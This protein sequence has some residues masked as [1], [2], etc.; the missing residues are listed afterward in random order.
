MLGKRKQR[1]YSTGKKPVRKKTTTVRK[2]YQRSNGYD[3]VGVGLYGRFNVPK[4]PRRAEKKFTD[5]FFDATLN[6]AFNSQITIPSLFV[7]PRGDGP[8]QRIGSKVF[9]EKVTFRYKIVP[10]ALNT[11]TAS[12]QP[13]PVVR[14]MIV[15]DMQSNAT[16]PDPTDVV[17][18]KSYQMNPAD[19]DAVPAVLDTEQS[20][21]YMNISNSKRFRI[22]HDKMHT[23]Q[24]DIAA[25]ITTADPA[26]KEIYYRYTPK[27]VDK[28]KNLKYDVE[29][30]VTNTN[31]WFTGLK[32][33][34]IFVVLFSDN[35]FNNQPIAFKWY[36]R[37]RYTDS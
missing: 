34:N 2:T 3:R 32:S 14:V 27:V 16:V 35:T 7:I 18:I 22:L 17:E 5:L 10:T 26:V 21:A 20:L 4:A 25:N 23:F 15:Q 33:A 12:A 9:A 24:Q 8:S 29:Y 1:G 36:S 19:P 37:T 13:T 6:A 31:G 30:D 11:T 28:T